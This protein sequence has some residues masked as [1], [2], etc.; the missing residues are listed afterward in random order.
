MTLLQ[1][2]QNLFGQ[3]LNEE[4]QPGEPGVQNPPASPNSPVPPVPSNNLAPIVMH[5]TEL[6]AA[7]AT[8]APKKPVVLEGWYNS[9]TRTI[10]ESKVTDPDVLASLKLINDVNTKMMNDRLIA[11]A[12]SAEIASHKATVSAATLQKVLDLSKVTVVDGKVTGV[13]EAVTALKST[14]PK[15]FQANPS[16]SPLT[17]GFNPA[18]PGVKQ[19]PRSFVEAAQIESAAKQ[20]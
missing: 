15:M 19:A 18:T 14:E 17:E 10:D 3:R 8:P 16:G 11:D 5:T 7:P 4:V 13:K 12:V 9:T 6:N 20:A 1:M 2:L